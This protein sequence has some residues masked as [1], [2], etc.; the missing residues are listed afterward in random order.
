MLVHVVK[1]KSSTKVQY[2]PAMTL[3][4]NTHSP[5][6]KDKATFVCSVEIQTFMLAGAL[7]IKK[8]SRAPRQIGNVALVG[9]QSQS[10]Y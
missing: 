8:S 9:C 4:S 10:A 3:L 2:V 6:N 5:G 7:A 1:S